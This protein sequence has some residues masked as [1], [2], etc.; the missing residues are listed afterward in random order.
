MVLC[1][2]QWRSERHSKSQICSLREAHVKDITCCP[3]LF[4][5]YTHR[6]VV[7]GKKGKENCKGVLHLGYDSKYS[8]VLR[9]IALFL[10]TLGQMRVEWEEHTDILQYIT[11]I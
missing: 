2:Y 8:N 4:N 5:I 6:N 7:L 1:V 10:L 3:F 9:T 11:K